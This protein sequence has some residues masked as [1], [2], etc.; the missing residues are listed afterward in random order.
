MIRFG[1]QKGLLKTA[2]LSHGRR[3]FAAC[4]RLFQTVAGTLRKSYI[5]SL[6]Q[7]IK[8]L[9]NLTRHRKNKPF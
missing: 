9:Y 6:E 3:I 8:F 2:K 4:V 1:C 7:E 5:R